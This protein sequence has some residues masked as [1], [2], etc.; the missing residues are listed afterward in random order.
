MAR[1][2]VEELNAELIALQN[3]KDAALKAYAKRLVKLR[4]RRDEAIA[5]ERAKGIKERLAPAEIEA[6][7]A[8]LGV[9]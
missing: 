7:K 8:E 3:E 4:K 6:L 2:S 1:K 5:R 9:S